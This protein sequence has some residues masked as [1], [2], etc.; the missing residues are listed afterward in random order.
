MMRT[1]LGLFVLVLGLSGSAVAC[2]LCGDLRDRRTLR[3]EATKAEF[4]I[5][6]E[7]GN[8]RLDPTT[9]SGTVDITIQA[10]IKDHAFRGNRNIL[11]LPRYL[12]V[13]ARNPPK[14]LLF[15]NVTGKTLDPYAGGPVPSPDVVA[16][17]RTGLTLDAKDHGAILRYAYEHLDASDATVA[18]DAFLELARASDAEVA[19]LAP[20][21]SPVRLRTLLKNRDTPVER[22]GLFAYLLAACGQP[23]DADLLADRLRA[24]QPDEQRALSGLLVGYLLLR[25]REAWALAEATVSDARQPFHKRYAVITALR[26]WH[27]VRPD[28]GKESA[29]KVYA[30]ALAHDDTADLVV[31]DLRRRQWWDQTPTVLALA[32]R[33]GFQVPILKRNVVRYALCCP[34]AEARRLVETVARSEPDL[35]ADVREGLEFENL[36]PVRP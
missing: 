8:A 36:A 11:T 3:E 33:E 28:Q 17:L 24:L 4:V 18:A 22:I 9:G 15:C 23:E 29:L 12:P 30:A 16:Y 1:L 2:T 21:L 35:V 19:A 5:Y 32:Q 31:E 14:A 26:F 10:V 6:G 7:L 20:T 13:D 25:P 34:A 27:S